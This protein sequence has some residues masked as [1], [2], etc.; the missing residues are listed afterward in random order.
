MPQR[1]H[2]HAF[3]L[4]ELSIVLVILG[5]LTGGILAGQSLIRAAEIRAVATELQRYATG[6]HSFRDKYFAIPGDFREATR[7]W[8]R[9]TVS[10]DCVSNAGMTSAGAPGA[11]DGNGNGIVSTAGAANQSGE[12]FQVWRQLALAGLIEGT[13]TGIAGT[14]GYDDFDRGLNSPASRLGNNIWRLRTLG[15]LS[16]TVTGTVVSTFAL[17]YGIALESGQ[18]EAGTSLLK[19]EEAWNL[20]TKMDDGQPAQGSFIARPWDACTNAA[21]RNDL[22]SAYKLSDTTASCKTILRNLF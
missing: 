8:N 18:T 15:D 16:G 13:Y 12:E 4:I 5:L 14:G 22:T 11:C 9:Q 6:M 2:R 21:S 7:F 17:S 20:D 19:P 3:S 1:H 10:S